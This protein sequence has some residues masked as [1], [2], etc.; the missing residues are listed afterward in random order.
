VKIL[1]YLK[2]S[3][4]EMAPLRQADLNRS[5]LKSVL[6]KQKLDSPLGTIK[7]LA[8]CFIIWFLIVFLSAVAPI[9]FHQ[10]ETKLV[11]WEFSSVSE[12]KLKELFL[13]NM[14]TKLQKNFIK[15]QK[16]GIESMK[17]M[18]WLYGKTS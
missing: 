2:L 16:P 14:Q 18:A 12:N 17:I 11:S 3:T 1:K 15:K 7:L 10:R 6:S 9:L 4:R 13:K 8:L 5:L